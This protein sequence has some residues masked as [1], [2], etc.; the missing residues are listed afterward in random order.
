MRHLLITSA[1]VF[2]FSSLAAAMQPE[3]VASYIVAPVQGG[4]ICV[5]A[6][7]QRGQPVFVHHLVDGNLVYTSDDRKERQS[8]NAENSVIEANHDRVGMALVLDPEAITEPESALQSGAEQRVG[9][10]DE[11]MSRLIDLRPSAGTLTLNDALGPRDADI[12]DNMTCVR[13]AIQR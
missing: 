6:S 3:Q 2:S 11:I 4:I 9:I 5:K 1:T 12:V 8:S 13:N 10:V 7:A